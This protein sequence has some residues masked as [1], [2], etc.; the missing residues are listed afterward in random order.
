MSRRVVVTGLGLISPLG[1]DAEATWSGLVAGRSG[2]GDIT[3]FDC[4]DFSVRIAA[5]VKG[6]DSSQ[7]FETKELKKFDL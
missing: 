1:L 7:W 5:E 4:T 3:R 2:A 6:F